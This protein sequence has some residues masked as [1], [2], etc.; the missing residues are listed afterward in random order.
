M[1][2][3]LAHR[4]GN[5]APELDVFALGGAVHGAVGDGERVDLRVAH[6]LRG[7]ERVGVGARERAHV[8][9]HAGQHAQLA[10][11]RDAAL[12]R[13]EHHLARELHVLLE[14]QRRPVDHD[15]GVAARDGRLDACHVAPVVE[16]QNDGDG[17][18]LAKA[19]HRV[20]D[21]A[22]AGYLVLRGAV[23]EVGPAAHEGVGE[24]GALQDRGA[25]EGLVDLDHGLGLAHGVD[26]ERAL[27]IAA[28][29]GG[30]QHGL[31]R[32]EHP[33]LLLPGGTRVPPLWRPSRA[34]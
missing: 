5:L 21:V 10:L 16:V 32:D 4:D 14:G 11:H 18:V 33:G 19:P 25:A 17:A 29:T 7:R 34:S 24:V 1:Q 30:V 13:I 9:L 8:V 2:Q 3:A 23:G 6:E 28:P 20:A 15:R 26:V 31:E 12:V 27:G 22:R